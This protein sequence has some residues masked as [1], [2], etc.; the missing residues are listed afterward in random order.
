MSKNC[1]NDNNNN[2]NNNKN[3]L[4]SSLLLNDYQGSIYCGSVFQNILK[5]SLNM[6]DVERRMR[7]NMRKKYLTNSND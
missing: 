6:K 3:N 1:Y 2:N 7:K 4:F 5:I